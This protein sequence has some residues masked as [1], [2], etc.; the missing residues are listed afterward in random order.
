MKKQELPLLNLRYHPM[1]G[2]RENRRGSAAPGQ[3][4]DRP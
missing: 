1:P 2:D 3:I 4:P